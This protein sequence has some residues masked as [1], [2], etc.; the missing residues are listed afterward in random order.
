MS[1]LQSLI[2]WQ[3]D[4][5]WWPPEDFEG[6]GRGLFGCTIPVFA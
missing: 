6:D 2:R 1:I 5:E 3:Y 4:D